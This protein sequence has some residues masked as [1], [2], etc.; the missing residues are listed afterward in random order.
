MKP[1]ILFHG[2]QKLQ[3]ILAPKQA[4]G[5]TAEDCLCGIYATSERKIAALFAINYIGY[6][7]DARFDIERDGGAYY[8]YLHKTK[9]DWE[10]VGY[11]YHL[12][13]DSFEK[14]DSNQWISHQSVKPIQIEVIHP[15]DFK[16]YIRI[17]GQ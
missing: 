9:V 5:F 7:E 1:K 3:T 8:A 17:I 4:M 15:N 13:S 16:K 12:A 2:S 6:S 10:Q 14:L 11:L